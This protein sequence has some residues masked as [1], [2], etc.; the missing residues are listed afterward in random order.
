MVMHTQGRRKWGGSE[1]AGGGGAC[2]DTL[3]SDFILLEIES[4]LIMTESCYNN[5]GLKKWGG[6]SPP[7]PTAMTWSSKVRPGFKCTHS[8]MFVRDGWMVQVERLAL[9]SY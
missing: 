6:R 1:P 8:S 4:E 9:N 5:M 2:I 7:T 3:P